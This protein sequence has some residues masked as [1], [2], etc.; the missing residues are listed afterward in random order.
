MLY[1][2]TGWMYPLSP[3]GCNFCPA[4]NPNLN[5]P[6]RGTGVSARTAKKGMCRVCARMCVHSSVCPNRPTGMEL[7]RAF[8]SFAW[9]FGVCVFNNC[10]IHLFRFE[11]REKSWGRQKQLKHIHVDMLAYS[12]FSHKK[13]TDQITVGFFCPFRIT[14]LLSKLLPSTSTLSCLSLSRSPVQYRPPDAQP[15]VDEEECKDQLLKAVFYQKA[16]STT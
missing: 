5:S 8:I 1:S 3:A 10:Q 13:Q 9:A 15:F 6:L 12:G 2:L 7:I 16:I 14:A 4:R 11:S